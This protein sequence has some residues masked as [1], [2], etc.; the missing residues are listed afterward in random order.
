MTD[1]QTVETK[2]KDFYKDYPFYAGMIV[3][4]IVAL[5]IRHFI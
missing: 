2:A 3:G 5:V 1:L 4:A